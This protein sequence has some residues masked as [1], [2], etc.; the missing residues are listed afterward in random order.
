MKSR[1]C[2]QEVL[3][4]K[5]YDVPYPYVCDLRDTAAAHIAA[6]EMRHARVWADLFSC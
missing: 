4:H 5:I 1:P 2:G 3:E 6:I